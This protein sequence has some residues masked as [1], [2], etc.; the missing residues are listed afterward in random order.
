MKWQQTLDGV[1]RL[2]VSATSQ[3]RDAAKF[4]GLKRQLTT[5]NVDRN[6]KKTSQWTTLKTSQKSDAEN[7]DWT[8]LEHRQLRASK[9]ESRMTQWRRKRRRRFERRST[10]RKILRCRRWLP[11]CRRSTRC[12]RAGKFRESP[13][14]SGSEWARERGNEDWKQGD[15]KIRKKIAKFFKNS[16]KSH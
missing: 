15:Q 9:W 7:V 10:I 11:W 6:D 8:K 5:L 2:T 1:S 13:K 16:P 14:R 12:R 3:K 4:S